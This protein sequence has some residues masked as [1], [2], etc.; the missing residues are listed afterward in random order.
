MPDGFDA[1][2]HTYDGQTRTVFVAGQGPPVVVMHEIPGLHPG[3]VRFARHLVS[4]GFTVWMP[5]LFGTP[6]Q[7]VGVRYTAQSLGRACVSR[8]FTTWALGQASPVVGWLRQLAAHAHE[9]SGQP[10]GAIGMCLTGGFALAMAVD[11]HLAA[12]VLSQPS[13]P[14]ALSPSRARSI[15]CSEADLQR[16]VQRQVCVLGLRF[17][18]D[19]MVPAARFSMLKERLGERFEAFEI[20]SSLGS[21]VK[22]WAHSVLGVDFVDDPSHPTFA[23]QQRVVDFFRTQLTTEG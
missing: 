3:V 14:F 5:S 21:G 12:P 2:Q 13:C 8:S 9:V 23:A 19:V 7:P 1:Q 4:E 20:D 16:V 10:V 6:D 18:G 15:D 11:D 22:P 17:T